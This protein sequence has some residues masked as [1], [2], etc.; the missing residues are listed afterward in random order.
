MNAQKGFTL[1]ELMIVVAIIGILA[2]IA[3]PA[4]RDYTQNSA[5]GGCLAEAKAYMSTAVADAANN[6]APATYTPAACSAAPTTTP[7]IDTYKENTTITFI[8]Q[9]RGNAAKLQNVTCGGGTGSCSLAAAT[10]TTTTTT[11]SGF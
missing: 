7:S 10:T 9:T 1:I 2:A 3:L 6:V 8:P 4:Y 11:T 5:N